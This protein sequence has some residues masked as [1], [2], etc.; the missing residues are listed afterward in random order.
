[1]TAGMIHL[2]D[3]LGL[4]R[5]LAD[6]DGAADVG[7][8]GR[9]RPGST[10][11][12]CGSGPTTR[13]RRRS[14]TVDGDDGDER[15]SLTPEAVAVLAVARPRGVRHG[16]VPPTCPQ[17]MA[18][19][20]RLP[21]SFRTGLGLRLRQPRAGGRGR[22]RAQLRAVE[23]G[24]PAADRAADARRRRR[25][26]RGRR[27][28]SPTSGAAPAAPCCC[29]PR[30]SRPARFAG[31]DISQHAL[32]RADDAP[33]RGRVWPTP[34]STTRAS[35]PLPTDH[36]RRPR[37]DV[38]LHPRHDRP[39]G[40]DGGD[41]RRRSPTTARGC[42]STSRPSTRSPR[43]SRKNPM[44]SLMYGISVLSCMSS[45]LSEPGGAG[46][47]TLGL[48]PSRAEAMARDA[49]F[50][51]VPPA[52][53][54]PRRQR[55]LR[56]PAVTAAARPI[57]V[58]IDR[59]AP[60]PWSPARPAAWAGH[61]PPVRR[62]GRP[63]RRRR[64]RPG[65]ASTPSSPRSPTPTAPTPPIGVVTDVG[66]LG[67]AA[68]RSSTTVVERVRRHRHPRQQRRRGPADV[69]PAGRRRLRRQL[70]PHG[71]RQPHR[72]RPPRP[73]RRA[74]PRRRAAR[75]GSSTSP[76]PRRS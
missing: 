3:R 69:H 71:R 10:S 61:G 43:T 55:L 63:R 20:E 30:R 50:T 74:V 29:S 66:D 68:P 60:A 56:D 49:G 41:P 45:A 38:R 76:R 54:R 40:D 8:A 9:A 31:Y 23:P 65:R 53:R 2:G 32:D 48:P 62:R 6:A 35:E 17:T 25:Q 34:R 4:Y 24:P 15:F 57:A 75:A 58:P 73:P 12:G 28:R 47:G 33:R 22:H 5:A 7:R 36:S 21:E 1:M 52:A 14:S 59:R 44:A 37:H 11:A 72:P 19:L 26:A 64:P 46:L 16:H 13:R 18:A 39:A 67:A 42:S 51:Q 70:G 27:P